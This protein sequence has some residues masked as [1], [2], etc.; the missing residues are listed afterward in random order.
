MGS[1]KEIITAIKSCDPT[2]SVVE[3]QALYDTVSKASVED[4][5]R[6]GA[7]YYNQ[8]SVAYQNMQELCNKVPEALDQ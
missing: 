7:T 4:F 1:I 8:M 2:A 6:N 3:T 5:A